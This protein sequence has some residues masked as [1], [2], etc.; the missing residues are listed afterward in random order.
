MVIFIEGDA[1]TNNAC[2]T[3]TAGCNSRTAGDWT[4]DT[5]YPVCNPEG[6]A[7]NSFGEKYQVMYYPTMYFISAKDKKVHKADQLSATELEELLKQ[8]PADTK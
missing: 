6:S 2:V 7:A 3:N 5:P 1:R 4:K 8:Y